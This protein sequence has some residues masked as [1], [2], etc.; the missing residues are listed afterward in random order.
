[1]GNKDGEIG[2][3]EPATCQCSDRAKFHTHSQHALRTMLCSCQSSKNCAHAYTFENKQQR[4][5]CRQSHAACPG[6]QGRCA[7]LACHF[8][9]AF[10]IREAVLKNPVGHTC[11]AQA[12]RQGVQG[13][14][15][16]PKTGRHACMVMACFCYPTALCESC[17]EV[18]VAPLPES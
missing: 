14:N 16:L 7:R 8:V 17:D 5:H 1:M 9:T 10:P 13:S 11:R 18:L 3:R 6:I 15:N 4:D 2:S 12:H